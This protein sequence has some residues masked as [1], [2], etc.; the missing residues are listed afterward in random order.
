MP[1]TT[2]FSTVVIFWIY[3]K[4]AHIVT[5][6]ARKGVFSEL[7]YAYDLIL[8]SE[9]IEI[10]RNKIVEWKET[11]ECKGLKV[12]LWKTKAMVSVFLQRMACIKVILTHLGSAA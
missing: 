10:L 1:T 3:F 7:L 8:R 11:F 5:E 6:L 4:L 9:T 12:N 2:I